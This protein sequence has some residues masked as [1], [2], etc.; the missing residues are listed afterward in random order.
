[1][2]TTFIKTGDCKRI[3]VSGAGEVAEIVNPALCGAHNVLKLT[4][5]R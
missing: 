2:T 1:M 3:K 4:A 5:E